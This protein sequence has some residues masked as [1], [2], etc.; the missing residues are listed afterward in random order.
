MNVI[1]PEVG[2]EPLRDRIPEQAL[3]LLAHKRKLKC[4]RIRLPHD[5]LDAVHDVVETAARS[6]QCFLRLLALVNVANKTGEERRFDMGNACDGQFNWKLRSVPPHRG[7][8]NAASQNDRLSAGEITAQS[9]I[10][11]FAKGGRNDQFGHLL[12]DSF[13]PTVA[14]H[15][16]GRGIELHYFSGGIH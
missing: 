1:T 14:E 11:P 12:S 16:L 13:G 7:D 5:A 3:G 4:L 8:L 2:F 6:F 10:V 9:T 15:S